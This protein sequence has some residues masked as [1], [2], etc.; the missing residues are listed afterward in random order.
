MSAF[1]EHSI[2]LLPPVVANQIAA[3]EVVERP[4][5]VV[6]ELLENSLDAGA[7]EI[8]ISVEQGGVK[9]LRVRDNGCGIRREELALALARH[10]TSK[11][12]SSDDLY[13]VASLGFRGEAL[14]SI[15]SV[16]RVELI[17]RFFREEQGY[18]VRGDGQHFSVPEPAAHPIGTTVEIRDLFFNT[19]ARRK[20]LRS[21]K[22]EF[23]H[24]QET[25]RRIALSRFDLALRLQAEGKSVLILRPALDETARLQRVGG[26]CGPEF[27]QHALPLEHSG[28][29]LALSGWLARPLFSRSQ[30]DMQYFF[31]NG[32]MVRD[33]LLT[34]AI[35]QAY[36]DVLYHGRH[37]AF[38][39]YLRLNPEQVDVNVHP[40]KHEVRFV[41]SGQVHDFVYAAAHRALAE[42]RPAGQRREAD[43]LEAPVPSLGGR[44]EENPHASWEGRCPELIEGRR[45]HRPQPTLP[46]PQAPQAYRALYAEPSADS[47]AAR[48][49]ASL[50]DAPLGY[51]LGQLRGIYILAENAQGLVLVDMH[52]AHERITYERLKS[53]VEQKQ[54]IARQGLLLPLSLAVSRGEADCAEEHLELFAE[55]GFSLQR[56]GPESLLVRDVP[57]LL[58]QAEIGQLLRDVLADL[59]RFGGSRR[60]REH[61]DEILATL[62]CHASVRAGH[63]LSLAE[64]NALL[65]EMETTL[66]SD[67]CN[68]GRPTWTQL[69]M[70]QLDALFLRGR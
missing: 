24:I 11:I 60:L 12:S 43:E 13:R 63:K 44:G 28:G 15:A 48:P 5:S 69:T 16:A 37:P 8:E 59:L 4:A 39:L 65:R 22:T 42:T 62:A 49:G 18:L 61:L 26:V 33:K 45:G 32:R 21:D 70:Q 27:T 40:A 46:L 66:R 19:P 1:P 14:A 35:R 2:H 3:G 30:P 23:G 51:A 55:L 50:P 7:S 25:V 38:V 64:M 57:A 56:A 41:D 9:L 29:E 52:A 17:S 20:F 67:Q 10:A 36:Q 6:K 54:A 31:V 47:P 34:H 58:A 68:H 53:A